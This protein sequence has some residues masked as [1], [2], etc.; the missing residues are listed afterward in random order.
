MFDFLYAPSG[1]NTGRNDED[2][3]EKEEVS[4]FW[5]KDFF[6]AWPR[7][8]WREIILKIVFLCRLQLREKKR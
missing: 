7:N 4:C 3:A 2:E 6:F 1:C 8:E 5:R